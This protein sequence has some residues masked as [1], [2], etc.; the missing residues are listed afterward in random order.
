MRLLL[1]FS[2]IALMLNVLFLIGWAN[3]YSPFMDEG[4]IHANIIIWGY[5]LSVY[6][7]IFLHLIFLVNILLGKKLTDIIPRWLLL[8]NFFLLVFQLF[9]R[10]IL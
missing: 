9:T 6:F 10:A 3:Q 5:L 1:F 7:N 4:T 8:L 2:W